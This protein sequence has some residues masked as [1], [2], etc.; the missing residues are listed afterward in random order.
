V[1]RDVMAG[2]VAAVL[3]T[4]ARQGG[5]LA[6]GTLAFRTSETLEKSIQA[7]SGFRG[8][9]SSLLVRL[10]ESLVESVLLVCLLLVFR[11]VLRKQALAAVAFVAWGGLWSVAAGG[12]PLLSMVAGVVA[13]VLILRVGLLALLSFSW[14]CDSLA[15]LPIDFGTWYSGRSLVALAML[16]AVAI[17][18]FSISLAGRSPFGTLLEE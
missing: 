7:L 14:F 12:D 16:I 18:A 1:G 13:L 10:P 17:W 2:G 5:G 9:V 3:Y 11:V 4:L 15:L 8:F 6:R